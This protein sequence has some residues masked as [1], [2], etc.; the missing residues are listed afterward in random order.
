LALTA[1][2]VMQYARLKALI[3]QDVDRDG[4]ETVTM[5]S[6]LFRQLLIGA[7]RMKSVF[8]EKYYLENNPDVEEA[9]RKGEIESGAAHYY[10]TGYFEDKLPKK[11]LVDEKYYV[12][13]HA[14]I[15]EAVRSGAIESAQQ[16]FE[17]HGY[18]EGRLPF[19]GFTL[20]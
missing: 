18:R 5:P 14:D 4:Q 20:F 2:A 12:F 3:K 10:Q 16:H 17:N 9:V 15:A 6:D 13:G 7:L 19:A 1:D 8:D 11:L